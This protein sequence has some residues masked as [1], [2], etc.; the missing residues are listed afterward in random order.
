MS[1]EFPELGIYTLPG[2]INDPQ[3]TLE[4]VPLAEQLGIGSIWPAERYDFKNV[5]VLCGAAAATTSQ[6]KI[7]TGLMNY[8]THHPMELCSFGATM[9]HL[10]GNRFTLGLGRGFDAL[11]HIFG[12]KRANIRG[13][14]EIAD[15]LRLLWSGQTFSGEN[16]LGKFPYLF[17]N[18]PPQ[19]APPILLGAVGPKTL[20]M[21]GRVYDGVLLHPCL[22]DQAIAEASE[23]VRN[24]A[25][26]AGRERS[27]CKVWAT[28]VTAADQSEE[29]TMAIG[30]ARLL[31][32]LHMQDYGELLCRVNHWDAAVLK[33]VRDH[34]LFEGGKSADQDFTRYETAEVSALFPDHWMKDSA[35]LGSV[36]HCAGRINDQFA[37]GADGVLFH[38]S[39]PRQ[40]ERLL[41]AY[42]GVRRSD[43]FDANDPWFVPSPPGTGLVLGDKGV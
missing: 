5:E 22:T 29:E 18:E 10:S 27:A 17:M 8:P 6:I 26:A 12:T 33:K 19:H 21:A 20:A 39:A 38:G 23:I 36:E 7:A 28:L 2:R 37:A 40:V 16:S 14:T 13:L 32:Y 43:F 41:E 4:E 42:R 34:P 3:R 11:Y 24:A 1:Q 30:P 9:S 15:L 31:T 35:A 25:E